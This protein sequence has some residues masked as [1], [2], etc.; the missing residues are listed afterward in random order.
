V[1]LLIPLITDLPVD[2]HWRVRF[3]FFV[4]GFDTGAVLGSVF[5]D[6]GLAPG[7]PEDS[8]EVNINGQTQTL[9]AKQD[10]RGHKEEVEIVMDGQR[11]LYTFNFRSSK[12]VGQ[13]HPFITA[14]EIALIKDRLPSPPPDGPMGTIESQVADAI[15]G[16]LLQPD[17]KVSNG[18][19]KKAWKL[20]DE[21]KLLL[22][23]G[24]SLVREISYHK[25]KLK[26]EIPAGSFS[27]M[28]V[29]PK[30]YTNF[31]Q[32]CVVLPK[33]QKTFLGQ[34]S[35]SPWLNPGN[36]RIVLNWG[37]T[38]KDLDSYLHVP[39]AD[40]AKKE[41]TI[42]Y[43]VKKCN[44]NLLSEVR[45]DLDA[46]GHNRMGGNPETITFGLVTAG[47]YVFRVMEYKGKDSDSLMQSGATVSFYSEDFVRT[48]MIGRDGYVVG[49]NWFVFYI[50]GATKEIK[51]CDRASCPETLCAAGGYRKKSGG[52]FL[53]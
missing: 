37:S 23:Q 43:K 24:S 32:D 19:V 35:L 22:F 2:G 8:I 28:V 30:F 48:F 6:E 10:L 9:V 47:K 29:Y 45:L 3:A 51:P 38:P 42:S 49:I 34:I 41:C 5:P 18:Y 20:G 12:G 1:H 13:L 52:Q 53:C 11:M 4:P 17:K 14:A 27:C 15:D 26:E 7:S 16:K 46:T 33:P 31:I 40:P 39:N 21:A 36:T 50:D 25:G 44:K